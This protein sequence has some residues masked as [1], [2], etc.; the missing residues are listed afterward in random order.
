MTRTRFKLDIVEV[1]LIVVF[2]VI[3]TR[4]ASSVNPL[5]TDP[6]ARWLESTYGP[7]RNSQFIEEWIIRDFFKERRGGF[8]LDVG[9]S[10]HQMNSNTY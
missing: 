5:L 4:A 9:A 7:E 3:A 2:A 10:H 1:T 8:F 6:S